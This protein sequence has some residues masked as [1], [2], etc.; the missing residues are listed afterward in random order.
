VQALN[1]PIEI[2]HFGHGRNAAFFAAPIT[3]PKSIVPPDR[4]PVRVP[5][6]IVVVQPV[7]LRRVTT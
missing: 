2:H 3:G 7:V 4:R 5:A 6:R 1:R